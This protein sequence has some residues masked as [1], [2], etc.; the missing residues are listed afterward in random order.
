MGLPKTVG[1]YGG[2]LGSLVK[3]IYLFIYNGTQSLIFEELQDYLLKLSFY[4]YS[5]FEVL[6]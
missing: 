4:F 3:N 6:F 5:Q 2:L 1:F